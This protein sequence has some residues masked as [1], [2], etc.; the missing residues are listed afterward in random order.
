MLDPHL[1]RFVAAI[2]LAFTLTALPAA[3]TTA[4]TGAINGRVQNVAPGQYLNNAR[5]TVKGTSLSDLT[6]ESGTYRIAQVPAGTAVLQVFYTGLDPE[7]VTVR[8]TGGGTVVQ[9]VNLTSA[10]LFGKSQGTVKLDAFVVSTGRDTNA[11]SIAVNEQRFAPNLKN[12]VNTDAF[13]DVTDGNVGEFLKFLPGITT[14]TDVNEGG[15]VTTISVRG[16]SSGMT[17]VSSDGA[18]LANTGSA[19]GNIRTFY[20]SQVS[21]NNVAR[22]EVTKAPTP[23]TPADTLAGSVNMVSKSAFERK[24]AQFNYSVS[25]TGSSQNLS[26]QREPFV[27]DARVRKILPGVMFDYTLPV[28]RDFGIVVTG[29]SIDRHTDQALNTKTYGTGAAGASNA[30]PYLQAIRFLE[31]PRLAYRRSLAVK[32]D[33]RVAT[34]SVLSAGFQTSAFLNERS[35]IE[36]AISAGTNATPAVAGGKPLTFGPDFTSG[37]TGRGSMTLMGGADFQQPGRTRAG[38]FRYRFDDGKWRIEA[39]LDHSISIGAVR[40]SNASPP[41]FRAMAYSFAVPIRVQFNDLGDVAPRTIRLFDNNEREVSMFELRNYRLATAQSTFR[42]FTD[43]LG[44]GKLDVRRQLPFVPFPAAVQAGFLTRTQERDIR[45][46][47][48]I[49]TYSGPADTSFMAHT[50]YRTRADPR[51][52]AMQWPSV[53]RAWAAWQANPGLF[54]QTPA[55]VV[56]TEQFKI[57]NSEYV[58][59]RVSAQYAMVELKP[60]ARLSLLGGVRR[61][62]TSVD[63]LGPIV[64][65]TAVWRRNADGSFARAADGSRIRKAEAGA[66]GSLQEL[67]LV[68]KERGFRANRLYDGNYPSLHLTYQQ[69]ANLIARAAYAETYGR[70]DF[71]NIIPNTSITELDINNDPSALDGRISVR[72]PG[73]KPWS[74]RNWDLSL[75]YYTPQGGLF[76]V[77][78]F[79][80]TI[81]GFFVSSTIIAT[82]QDLREFDL[83]PE[84]LGW[85]INS[86]A[87][88]GDARVDGVEFNAQHSLQA[89]GSWGRPFQVFLNGTKLKLYGNQRGNFS[90]FVRGTLS[91]GVTYNHRRFKVVA[92]W[93]HR[94]QRLD[95][96]VAALNPNG[97]SYTIPRTIMDLN[98]EFR[99]SPR[100]SAFASAQNVFAVSDKVERFGDNTP[101]YARRT[102]DTNTG[103][104]LTWGVRG[105]F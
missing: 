71:T 26:L 46:Y 35:P 89:L 38:N 72:N 53:V 104:L 29:Q 68:R 4:P 59:E 24:T 9:D 81:E 75:E 39:G 51:F 90:G 5:V 20:F 67:A 22:V 33:W 14:D 41:R 87:N 83:G 97:G 16:F 69:S 45:R 55:Q 86:T 7:E 47:N 80:K 43:S 49:W 54:T 8:I 31:G 3:E 60:F 100:L 40:D 18:Q 85:E 57:M 34:Y 74:A 101:A 11:A 64:D 84:Y 36:T 19:Q 15:T 76:S 93:N 91:W 17:R 65:P 77:G 63:G 48:P 42:D 105:S 95:S 58:R 61:E 88:G 62:R 30:N 25:L 13:G 79:R 50:E 32:A 2:G 12:V 10:A 6:D 99:V 98:A 94:G 82:E 102:S 66:V 56:A 21:A 96:V 73:L 44:S 92:R 23:A 103:V 1:S 37:A 27:N 70:P 78:A 52:Q 28:N